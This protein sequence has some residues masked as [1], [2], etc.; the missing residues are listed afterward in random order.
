M[1]GCVQHGASTLPDDAFHEFPVAGTAEIHLATGFQNIV[2]DDGGL[3]DEL[4]R[5][6]WTGAPRTATTSASRARP[7]SSSCTRPARRRSGRSSAACGR[8]RGDA[9]QIGA[10]LR[11]K[12]G[13]LFDEL[14]I[15]GTRDLVE[16]HVTRSPCARAAG[17]LGG[18]QGRHRRRVG[19]RGRRLRRVAALGQADELQ[20]RL[21][22][23]A[24]QPRAAAG[25]SVAS[26]QR[27]GASRRARA[28][29]A[30][31]EPVDGGVVD[32]GE[33]RERPRWRARHRGRRSPRRGRSAGRTR[34][35]REPI[36]EP[37]EL[38]IR[39]PIADAVRLR[40][41]ALDD[42]QHRSVSR[43]LRARATRRNPPNGRRRRSMP[44]RPDRAG[45]IVAGC[46]PARSAPSSHCARARLAARWLIPSARRTSGSDRGRRRRGGS[47]GRW[48]S[49][50]PRPARPDLA[51]ACANDLR[52]A[53][54]RDGG[55]RQ[56]CY[57]R[58]H[59]SARARRGHE[60]APA[61]GRGLS[62]ELVKASGRSRRPWP[63]SRRC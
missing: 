61:R 1:A 26:A 5:R 63:V 51:H 62:R 2:Y 12:F 47:P 32:P 21:I 30:G 43:S 31:P 50:A 41:A 33:R 15:A 4:R 54:A 6:C 42:G 25:D 14:G 56:T 28:R 19:L 11:A 53:S 3:P 49:T 23:Q 27:R 52:R 20:H 18:T 8:S 38:G 37:G 17:S 35:R 40:D 58:E 7:T 46:R 22:G 10:N 13:L 59:V 39:F 29:R 48:P 36:A 45:R 34:G 9:A 24:D 44:W 16:R 57:S 55:Q 60:E